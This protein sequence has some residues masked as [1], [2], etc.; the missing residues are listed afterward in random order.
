MRKAIVADQARDGWWLRLRRKGWRWQSTITFWIC[1]KG[2]VNRICWLDGIDW[3]WGKREWM[4]SRMTLGFDGTIYGNEEHWERTDWSE[5]RGG[6]SWVCTCWICDT[7]KTSKCRCGESSVI[8]TSDSK[9]EG[10]TGD[11]IWE[12]FQTQLRSSRKQVKTE[13]KDQTQGTLNS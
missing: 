12:L 4:K 1:F 9:E 5:E 7:W 13:V 2:T 11:I 10:V 8:D 6:K 3:A